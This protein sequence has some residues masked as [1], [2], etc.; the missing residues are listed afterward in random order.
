M[1]FLRPLLGCLATLCLLHAP[2]SGGNAVLDWNAEVLNATRLSRNPPPLAALHLA[3]FHAAIFD[4]VNGITHTHR[5]WLVTESAPAGANPDAAIAAAAHTVL[6]ALWGES[7][8][9]R[10]LEVAYAKA[11]AAI[12][13]GPAKTDGLAWGRKVAEAVL[14]VRA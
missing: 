6:V 11:L 1:K 2:L 12:P 8:N 10:N 7:T 13:D 3:T 14:A 9:P 4:A 5:G